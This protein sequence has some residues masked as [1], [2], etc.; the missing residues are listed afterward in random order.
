MSVSGPR[1]RDYGSAQ[2]LGPETGIMGQFLGPETDIMG[3]RY[4]MAP[5]VQKFREKQ[6]AKYACKT[7]L[8]LRLLC[9]SLKM[10][11]NWKHT[12]HISFNYR[13]YICK[14][15]SK[16]FSKQENLRDQLTSHKILQNVHKIL[17]D[18]ISRGSSAYLCIQRGEIFR[19]K[20]KLNIHD[21]VHHSN[22]K[23]YDCNL[24]GKICKSISNNT[25]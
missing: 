15:C 12:S 2:F 16:A 3:E 6:I 17:Q 13:P 19:I 18:V 24:C 1:N 20:T 5:Q 11:P 25:W 21:N 4:F 22:F 7:S 23:P 8:F 14:K 9:Q 10:N